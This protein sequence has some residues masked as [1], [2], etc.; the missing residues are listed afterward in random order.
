MFFSF[1]LTKSFSIPS[2]SSWMLEL[3]LDPKTLGVWTWRQSPS[4]KFEFRLR[5][6]A[7]GKCSC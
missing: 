6:P 1:Q 2:K 4:F 3:D 7:Y 5:S